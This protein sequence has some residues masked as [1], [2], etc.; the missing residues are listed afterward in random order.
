MTPLTLSHWPTPLDP[1]PRLAAAL[2]LGAGDLAVKRDD[3]T[4]FGGGNKVR[5]L[6]HLVADARSAGATVLVTSGGAQSN[7]ARMTAAAAARCGLGAVLVLGGTPTAEH[8]GNLALE[9]LLGARVVAAGDVDGDELDHRVAEVAEQLRAEGQVPAVLPLGGSSPTGARAYLAC[10]AELAEQ[11]PDAAHV[12]VAVGSGGTMAGLVAGLGA[13]RVLGVDTAAVPDPT[14]RVA[15][16]VAAL[17]H[18]PGPLRLRRDQA[19][20]GYGVLTPA[21]MAAM[22]TA[23]RT[24]GLLLD[25]VY[26][27]KALAGLAAAVADGSIRP[28]ERTVFLHTGGL[29]GLFGHPVARELAAELLAHA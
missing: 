19:G 3:L 24:E 6:E 20:D 26:T 4:D 23:A 27:A 2:G 12:V 11:A 21:A 25:P 17:G 29:P 5:K 15:G 28:G 14:E 8:P 18:S 22:R 13:D 1:A 7:H 9:E 10:A 16:L